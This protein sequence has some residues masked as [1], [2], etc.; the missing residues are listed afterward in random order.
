[1][2]KESYKKTPVPL[3]RRGGWNNYWIASDLLEFTSTGYGGHLFNQDMEKVEF[4]K[5]RVDALTDYAIDYL[6]NHRDRNKP[7]FLF[8]SYLEPHHQNTTKRYEGP[9]GSKEKFAD[10]EDPE[11][12]KGKSGDWKE[13]YPDYLGSCNSLDKNL[14]RLIEKLEDMGIR[15]NTVI[16]YTSDHGSHFRTRNGE[17]KRSCHES[18]VRIPLIVDGPGFNSGGIIEELVSLMDIP[19]T[20][21]GIAD[22]ETPSSM[23]GKPLQKLIQSNNEDWKE[24]VYIQISE[25]QVGRAIRTKKWKYSVSALDKNGW[26]HK[27]SLVYIEEFLYD[28]ESDPY[29]NNNLILLDEY[30]S[31]RD[32]LKEILKNRIIETG[33]R[34]PKILPR[35]GFNIIKYRIKLPL[36]I[37][38]WI[39]TRE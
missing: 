4:N 36:N 17:Y 10:F 19:P 28:L 3:E 25:S 24:E 22:I 13:S 16:I 27:D 37:I 21:L 5:Y 32:Q 15:D 9:V 18:S 39:F 38:K 34:M 14:G 7:F 20:F 23:R 29:E 11:D 26:L 2:F 12:L 8:I 35:T 31:E 6:D 30:K 1:M 33:E